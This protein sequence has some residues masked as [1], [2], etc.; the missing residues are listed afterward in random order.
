ML[1]NTGIESLFHS[2]QVF[3]AFKH[4]LGLF[5]IGLH[6]D[7]WAASGPY[8]Y[9]YAYVPEIVH[10]GP[11]CI[12]A[13]RGFH[14]LELDDFS[15]HGLMDLYRQELLAWSKIGRSLPDEIKERIRNAQ[16]RRNT[17]IGPEQWPCMD[18]QFRL[19][20]KNGKEEVEPFQV[21]KRK[22]IDRP[23]CNGQEFGLVSPKQYIQPGTIIKLE[24]PYHTQ[25]PELII[26]NLFAFDYTKTT[27]AIEIKEESD[28]EAEFNEMLD[29]F[30]GASLVKIE[31]EGHKSF[32]GQVDYRIQPKVEDI[33]HCGN[34]IF[35]QKGDEVR[36]TLT[37]EGK[38]DV[39]QVHWDK[40]TLPKYSVLSSFDK[41]GGLELTVDGD[42]SGAILVVRVQACG[43][44]DYVIPI[45]FS[46]KR[47][48]EIPSPECCYSEGRWRWM[49]AYKRLRGGPVTEVRLGFAMVPGNTKASVGIEGMRFLEEK[50]SFY[51]P[52]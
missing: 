14:N 47:K 6:Q 32:S 34:T 33:T 27:G 22:G 19:C 26:K 24:N 28:A 10:G 42:G 3:F 8:D 1:R 2:S 46:G 43:F 23:F 18:E 15:T 39:L 31:D 44:R 9:T 5:K 35:E 7:R 49:P 16:Y 20:R 51:Q 37:N 17:P 38:K 11:V 12:Q 50:D 29:L 25:T 30:Q 40:D 4:Q 21:L 36:M 52:K 13:N 48:I 41:A 45:D